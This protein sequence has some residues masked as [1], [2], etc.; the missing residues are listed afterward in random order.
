MGRFRVW[1]KDF[2]AIVF[3]KYLIASMIALAA[4]MGLFLQLIA[5]EAA[6]GA[7]SALAYSVGILVHW[8]L[9]SRLVFNGRVSRAKGLRVTQK[10]QFVISALV[11]LAI[12]TGV[13]AGGSYF[14]LDPRLAKLA[15][16]GLSFLTVWH[17]RNRYVFRSARQDALHS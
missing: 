14:G 5:L 11:G 15:A 12:T 17:L 1:L 9:S 16:V 3:S 4:D 10:A 6:P 8:I 13:V 7:A 2:Q